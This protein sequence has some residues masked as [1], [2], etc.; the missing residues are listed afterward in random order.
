MPDPVRRGKRLTFW[1]VLLLI[2]LAPSSAAAQ[3]R[4]PQWSEQSNVDLPGF[5]LERFEMARGRKEL[6]AQECKDNPL[7]RAYTFVRPGFQGRRAVCWL[8]S[9]VP[10]P[11]PSNCCVSGKLAGLHAF[12]G[13]FEPSTDIPGSD[14][15]VGAL[16]TADPKLCQA[17]CARDESCTGFTYVN[18]GVQGPT[19]ICYL[20]EGVLERKTGEACCTSGIKA[21]A[22][23]RFDFLRDV[24]MNGQDYSDF[25]VPT[26][27]SEVCQ[28]ACAA[29][30]DC[31]AYTY[32]K[33]T[34][35]V[36]EGRCWLKTGV[37]AQRAAQCC[38][39]GIKR[40]GRDAMGTIKGDFDLPGA[41]YHRITPRARSTHSSIC[42]DACGADS[43][44]RAF[45]YVKPGVQGSDPF[46]Y[47]KGNVPNGRS[48]KCCSSAGKR[49]EWI[50]K[51]L[52]ANS[53]PPIL[54]FSA[55]DPTRVIEGLSFPADMPNVR[56]PKGFKNCSASDRVI[57]NRSWALAHHNLWRAHQ[58]M[59]HINHRTRE[60]VGLWNYAFNNRMKT[61]TGDYSNW[62][63]RG[64]FG[65]YEARRFR[66][67]RRA[68]DKAFNERFR[69]MTFEVQ[70]RWPGKDGAHPCQT[71]YKRDPDANHIVLGK[72][73][74]C[75][76]FFNES[77]YNDTWRAKQIVHE[78]FHWLR[79]PGSAYW[80]SDSHDFWKSC[81]D[82]EAVRALY[83]DDA[84][85]LGMNRG[86]RDWNHNRAVLTNDNYALFSMMLGTR[87]YLGAMRSFPGEDFR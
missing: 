16:A 12:V 59:Q 77:S 57:I 25:A 79:I 75:S 42:A 6:C 29:D 58:V 74:F 47:L 80:V 81:G 2:V 18:P 34:N 53:T 20:K 63:P 50:G 36:P 71:A 87:V 35:T 15:R 14:Y 19:A 37:P 27:G 38:D 69:G 55:N 45:S 54:Y 1:L 72:I 33:S 66:L 10:K 26:G 64:W 41:D 82:Y 30:P 48:D 21:S 78:V 68:I 62:S 32:V 31:K 11:K 76:D 5:D 84:A 61:P 46:C 7:C 70:C 85:F 39:S 8:K 83:N 23:V 52:P 60:R 28:R 51:P 13:T 40:P 3:S 49:P 56:L 22:L 24:D 17:A 65:S 4:A 43:K 73:N 9:D 86:C 67:S 44:C